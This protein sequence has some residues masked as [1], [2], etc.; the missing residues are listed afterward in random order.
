MAPAPNWK[1]RTRS[2]TPGDSTD[3]TTLNA[4]RKRLARDRALRRRFV[5]QVTPGL[6]IDGD[7]PQFRVSMPKVGAVVD[8]LLSELLVEKSAFFDAVVAQWKTLFS[9]V[10]AR[11]GRFQDGRLFL[12]VNSSSTLF[13]LR[14]RLPRIK[15][16]LSTLPDAPKRFTLHL[17]IH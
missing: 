12:Y 7:A 6:P 16:A 14:S 3:L 1:E 2:M 8:G 17:E 11:P 15:K 10:P 9:D 13:T 5:N 4:E